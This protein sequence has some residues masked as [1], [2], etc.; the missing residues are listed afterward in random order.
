MMAVRV[1]YGCVSIN[2]N[3]HDNKIKASSIGIDTRGGAST[4]TFESNTIDGPD[5]DRGINSRGS[6]T[7]GNIFT[8][9]ASPMQ[10]MES[11]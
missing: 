4:N 10:N 6:K 3:I 8:D 5:G 1:P 7:S 9:N 2:N 11:G